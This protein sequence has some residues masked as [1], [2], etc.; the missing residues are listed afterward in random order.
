LRGRFGPP[1]RPN[2]EEGPPYMV[3]ELPFLAS[4]TM[5]MKLKPIL[6]FCFFILYISKPILLCRNFLFYAFIF[7]I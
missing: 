3:V 6:I 1:P 7:L 2:L 4:D 5:V